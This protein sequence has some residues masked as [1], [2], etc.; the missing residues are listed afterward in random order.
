MLALAGCT[1]APQA[2]TPSPTEA[3]PSTGITVE[4]WIDEE[5]GESFGVFAEQFKK[6]TGNNLEVVVKDFYALETEFP[7]Q[8]AEGPDLVIGSSE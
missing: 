5:L 3:A 4:V 8:A 1:A 7:A 6:D 2:P